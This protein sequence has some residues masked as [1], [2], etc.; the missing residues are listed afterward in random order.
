MVM[1][2][3]KSSSRLDNSAAR[4]ASS[5][6]CSG[7]VGAADLGGVAVD[8][9]ADRVMDG[10]EVGEV[11]SGSAAQLDDG[12]PSERAEDTGIRAGT[13]LACPLQAGPDP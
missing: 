12:A 1:I 10:D 8:A 9:D 11:G 2:I 5:R 7:V 3:V 4:S 6:A 13:G